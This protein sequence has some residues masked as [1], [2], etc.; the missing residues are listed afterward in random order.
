MNEKALHTLEYDKIIEQLVSFASSPSGKEA[1]RK[2]RPQTDRHWIETAQRETSDALTH[3]LTKGEL[4]FHGIQDIRPS[5]KR[6]D[7]GS[8]L[9]IHE[10]LDIARLLSAAASVKNYFRQALHEDDTTGDSLNER[11]QLIE[12]LS[13]L[14]QEIRRCIPDN[15]QIADDAST[16]L[17]QVRRQLRLTNDPL[18]SRTTQ[19][20]LEAVLPHGVAGIRPITMLGT[21]DTVCPSRQSTVPLSAA[22][23]TISPQPAPHSLSSLPLSS[24]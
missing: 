20:H 13:P 21:D 12:P 3:I 18:I 1:C 15:D 19:Q 24:N 2:L 5:L 14:M 8:S 17:S 11:Y 9:G 23:F 10:L 6:L 16:G 7:I 4:S 22:C